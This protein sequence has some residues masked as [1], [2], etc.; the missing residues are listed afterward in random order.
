M[1]F[2]IAEFSYV[3]QDI[4]I[5]KLAWAINHL[6]PKTASFP[7]AVCIPPEPPTPCKAHAPK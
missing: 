5:G 3:E 6:P 7:E 2:F 1:D 4:P